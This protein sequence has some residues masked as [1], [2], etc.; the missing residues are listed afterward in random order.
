MVFSVTSCW[1]AELSLTTSVVV[2]V[3]AHGS[4]SLPWSNSYPLM[5]RTLN[6]PIVLLIADLVC[7]D[8]LF[9]N[10]ALD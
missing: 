3:N 9:A 1:L 6:H 4:M 7:K 10:I 2:K 5:S 8:G